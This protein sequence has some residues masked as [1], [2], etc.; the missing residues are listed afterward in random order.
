MVTNSPPG[1]NV[2]FF[3]D[4]DD[5]EG[6]CNPG[7]YMYGTLYVSIDVS[8]FNY[9]PFFTSCTGTF[10]LVLDPS[11]TNR[12]QTLIVA[13]GI[14]SSGIFLLINGPVIN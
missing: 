4:E 1:R 9:S 13:D 14:H 2:P 11:I 3:D 6:C 7:E 8:Y 5:E 10:E 12:C